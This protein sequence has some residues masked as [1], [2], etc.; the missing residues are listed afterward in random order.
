MQISK[1]L[2]SLLITFG[3]MQVANATVIDFNSNPDGVYFIGS[4]TSNGF[5][6]ANAPVADNN[7]GTMSNFDSQGMTDGTIYLGAWSNTY[8]STG[9]VINATDNSLFSMQSFSFDNAYPVGYN[10]FGAT[11]NSR[12]DSLTVVGTFAN[13]STTSETFSGLSG[14]VAFETLTLNSSFQNLA[15]VTVTANGAP[16]VRALYDN[17]TVN[18]AAVPEPATYS[19]MLLGLGLMGFMVHR[20]KSA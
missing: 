12:T 5:T 10:V 13:G 11:G 3:A 1:I 16:Y 19:M 17:F 7:I 6:I 9:I 8:S 20:K 4:T 15:S 14:V 18:A 2:A